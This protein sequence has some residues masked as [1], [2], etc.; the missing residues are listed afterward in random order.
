MEQFSDNNFINITITNHG[1]TPYTIN[2]YKSLH[3]V[4]QKLAIFCLDDESF[5]ELNQQRLPVIRFD[6]TLRR[7]LPSEFVEW[8]Q[9][10]WSDIMIRKMEVIHTVL[11]QGYDLLYWDGDIFC[12]KDPT[13][14]LL[15][16]PQHDI[17]VQSDR[18]ANGAIPDELCMGFLMARSNP[19]TIKCF[20][21]SR[22]DPNNFK[23][24]QTYLNRVI[25][26]DKLSFLAL[27]QELFP[28]GS[29]WYA[30]SNKIKDQA[31]IVHYNYIASGHEKKERMRQYGM[32]IDEEL[33][34]PPPQNVGVIDFI[35]VGAHVGNT[36]N[37]PLYQIITDQQLRGVFIEPVSHLFRILK[38]NYGT[39]TG[40]YFENV[41]VTDSM[42]SQ[43]FYYLSK[44]QGAG[45]PWWYD[46]I[47]SLYPAHIS[48][49]VP[50]IVP[51]KTKVETVTI[52]H[53]ITK[54]QIKALKLLQIDAEGSDGII[55]RTFPFTTVKPETIIFENRHCTAPCRRGEK[56]CELVE[57]LKGLGYRIIVETDS[58]TVVTTLPSI[59]SLVPLIRK[60]TPSPLRQDHLKQIVERINH[61]NCSIVACGVDMQALCLLKA[62]AGSSNKIWSFHG[63]DPTEVAESLIRAKLSC[64][65]VMAVDG[66][67]VEPKIP[68]IGLLILDNCPMSCLET[69]YDKV[70]FGGAI[71]VRNSR[72]NN[73]EWFKVARNIKSIID[74]VNE[75]EYYWVKGSNANQWRWNDGEAIT[76][77]SN[78]KVTMK[79]GAVADWD[80]TGDGLIHIQWDNNHFILHEINGEL[81]GIQNDGCPV[82]AVLI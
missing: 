36:S 20:D 48:T 70:V 3:R 62:H 8:L 49:I 4:G 15:S 78:G 13:H 45:L 22:V 40:N 54:Y 75:N 5:Q 61:T 73:Y 52:E 10:G 64:N 1:Y 60:L 55:L 46:Q 11:K 16:L 50:D 29:F 53:I 80:L 28:N 67:P 69:F 33:I 56:Y 30:F 2:L 63:P 38:N 12:C 59:E 19:K 35:Q 25:R 51:Q 71:V 27:S 79:H 65:N 34:I 37:D 44:D 23:E 17:I 77:E 18:N 21:P 6:S 7:P 32:W 76:F 9:A 81:E 66:A 42:G 68:R 39:D 26:E 14:Y 43:D 82:R 31:Y 57:F 72:V 74:R 41:A 47:G 24:D 58:D